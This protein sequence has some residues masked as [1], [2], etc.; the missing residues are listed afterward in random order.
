VFVCI[1]H[2][3]KPQP[4]TSLIPICMLITH[5]YPAP[6]SITHT[7]ILEPLYSYEGARDLELARTTCRCCKWPSKYIHQ[8]ILILAEKVL[9]GVSQRSEADS[10]AKVVKRRVPILKRSAA[11]NPMV[12]IRPLN[13]SCR[14]SS[15]VSFARQPCHSHSPRHISPG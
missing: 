7:P 9:S 8:C 12:L 3:S 2:G 4:L 11:H 1:F 13:H 14:R 15:Y 10:M 5:I 6:S